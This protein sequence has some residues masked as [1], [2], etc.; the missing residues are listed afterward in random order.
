MY[1]EQITRIWVELSHHH[2]HHHQNHN[3]FCGISKL[4]VLSSPCSLFE[5]NIATGMIVTNI[6]QTCFDNLLKLKRI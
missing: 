2:H 5:K 3:Y 1:K 6:L 4:N